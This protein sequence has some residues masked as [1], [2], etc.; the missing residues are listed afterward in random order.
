MDDTV[1]TPASSHSFQDCIKI[2]GIY[3][4]QMIQQSH[5]K[6]KDEPL[7]EKI[8]GQVRFN[9]LIKVED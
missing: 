6:R 5:F 4:L 2:I 7:S 8:S 3:L 9:Y 1:V